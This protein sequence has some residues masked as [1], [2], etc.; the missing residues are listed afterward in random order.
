[1]NAPTVE[2]R[3]ATLLSW[4]V[5]LSLL[6][7]IAGCL[8]NLI[9]DRPGSPSFQKSAA[10]LIHCGIISLILTPA[11]RVIAACICYARQKDWIM[12]AMSATVVLIMLL[13]V[14]AAS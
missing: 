14:L 10:L 2:N 7:L 3:I 9:P 12:S 8:L 5:R 1:M 11:C 4:G 13:G 6:L